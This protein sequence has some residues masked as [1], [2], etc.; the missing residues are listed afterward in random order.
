MCGFAIGERDSCHRRKITGLICSSLVFCI[1]R[2]SV[3]IIRNRI[4]KDSA[5]RALPGASNTTYGRYARRA[6]VDGPIAT[7]SASHAL[8]NRLTSVGVLRQT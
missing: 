6:Y 2:V 8:Q 5:A 3:I 4:V 7:C 1:F